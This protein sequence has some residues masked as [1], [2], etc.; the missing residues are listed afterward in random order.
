MLAIAKS[1]IRRQSSIIEDVGDREGSSRR[2]NATG[3]SEGSSRKNRKRERGLAEIGVIPRIQAV[4]EMEDT[5]IKENGGNSMMF[6]ISDGSIQGS[7]ELV[8]RA[9][10]EALT[11]RELGVQYR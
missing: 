4:F 3:R 11:T 7:N 2:S 5:N 6:V 9:K 1:N 10:Q 8:Q